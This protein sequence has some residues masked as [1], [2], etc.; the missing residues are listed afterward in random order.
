MGTS[1][2][3]TS[4]RSKVGAKPRAS[5]KPKTLAEKIPYFIGCNTSAALPTELSARYKDYLNANLA[6][7]YSA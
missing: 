6:K 4:S 7:K 5:K 3:A 1:D 2:S